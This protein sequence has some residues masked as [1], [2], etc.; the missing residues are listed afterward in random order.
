MLEDPEKKKRLSD[1]ALERV[2]RDVMSGM[3]DVSLQLRKECL[4]TPTAGA[5]LTSHNNQEEMLE[6]SDELNKR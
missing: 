6:N 2:M 4:E 1:R 3:M 5:T